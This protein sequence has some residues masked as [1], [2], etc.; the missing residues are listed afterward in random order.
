MSRPGVLWCA[1]FAT[2]IA[3]VPEAGA[4]YEPAPEAYTITEVNSMFGP[5]VTMQIYRDGSKVLVDQSHEAAAGG[6]GTHIR[7]LYDLGTHENFTWDVSNRAVPCGRGTFSGDWGD[8]FALSAEMNADLTKQKAAP[9]GGATLNGIP[10]KVYGSK[11]P[12][13]EAKAWID[14][15]YGLLI[16]LMMG[17]KNGESQTMFEV[18]QLT[19]AKPAAAMFVLPPACSEAAKA[20]RVPTESEQIAADTGGNAQDYANAIMPPAS[21]NACAMQFKVVH[22]GNLEPISNG[23]QVAIDTTVD[24]E[25]PAHYVMGMSNTGR[26]T[27]SGGGLHEVTAQ[28]RNGVVVIPNLPAQFDM[29]VTFGKGGAASALIYRQCFSPET[30]MLLVVKNPDKLSDGARWLWVKNK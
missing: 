28:M 17:Q 21:K 19:L 5:T 30:T 10:T 14:I 29:E 23:F 15:K 26:T 2:L 22:A 1:L 13:G 6:Q 12:D 27:F 11:T 25:H 16:R 7:T 20:P 24:L 18:K 9:V 3:V 4:Q 8:P